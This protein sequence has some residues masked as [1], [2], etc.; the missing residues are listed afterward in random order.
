MTD[1]SRLWRV[2]L[3]KCAGLTRQVAGAVCMTAVLVGA[4]KLPTANA[5]TT[6]QV[7]PSGDVPC[8]VESIDYKGWKAQQISNR[9]VRL[10]IVPQNGG[11]LM[12]V[13]FNGHDFLFV[14]IGRASC[15]ER[16]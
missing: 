3:K 6:P 8:H 14:K 12:Q 13:N 11:R 10:I 7:K 9:W 5:Q 16:V 4:A 2:S 15:R 1:K